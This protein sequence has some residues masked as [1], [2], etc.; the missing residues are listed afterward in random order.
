MFNR[1]QWSSIGCLFSPPVLLWHLTP[2]GVSTDIKMWTSSPNTWAWEF[3]T[4]GTKPP[5]TIEPMAQIQSMQPHPSRSLPFLF[6]IMH[7]RRI[8]G[9]SNTQCII[10]IQTTGVN[11]KQTNQY[12]IIYQY[13]ISQTTGVNCKPVFLFDFATYNLQWLHRRSSQHRED[14]ELPFRVTDPLGPWPEGWQRLKCRN[15]PHYLSH[16]WSWVANESGNS[17]TMA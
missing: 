6:G 17:S 2:C 7:D 13:H 16:C 12:I 3:V 8:G 15:R 10:Y 4:P 14:Y 5:R 1:S 11:C 9:G